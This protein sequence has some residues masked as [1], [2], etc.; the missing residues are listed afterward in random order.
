MEAFGEGADE[1]DGV[2]AGP[3]GMEAVAA[4]YLE[5]AVG[6]KTFVGGHLVV[7]FVEDCVDMLEV[8]WEAS[9]KDVDLVAK[10]VD[11]PAS[12]LPEDYQWME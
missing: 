7:E 12:A 10:E 9:E 11:E 2:E 3:Y 4:A 5:V 6:K 8:D 1:C